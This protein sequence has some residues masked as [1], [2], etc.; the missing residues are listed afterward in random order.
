MRR[1]VFELRN[2]VLRQFAATLAV[3]SLVLLAS[4]SGTSAQSGTPAPDQGKTAAQPADAAKEATAQNQRRTDEFAEAAQAIN[5]P[6]G[7]P[8][9]VWLGRRVVRLMWRDDLDTA[10]RHLDLYDRFGCPGGHIQAA[11]RC[12][13]RFGA[14]IDPKVAETLDSRVHACWINPAAQP[15][16]AAAAA[17]QPAAQT[18]GAAPGPQPAASPAPA[19]SPSP[20]PQK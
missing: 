8:E 10:F 17:S 15:Q 9:C 1:R 14:Q 19:A 11:F 6:A 12:L 13:T 18:S 4:F 16:Q 20:A 2:T 5:G 3:S 7:N